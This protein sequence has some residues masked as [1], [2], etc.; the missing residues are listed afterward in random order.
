M[1]YIKEMKIVE[2]HEDGS[3]SLMYSVSKMPMMSER[4]NLISQ[5]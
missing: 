4:E 3:P 5:Y 1:K 2:R